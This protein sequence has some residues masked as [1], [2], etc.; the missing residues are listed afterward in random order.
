MI[1]K[2]ISA[3]ALLALLGS[4]QNAGAI[5]ILSGD[6]DGFGFTS[7]NDYENAQNGDPD[8]DG[9]GLIEAGEFLPDLDND[10][11]VQYYG[12]DQFDNREADEKS[13][14]V[15]AQWTD[16][17]LEDYYNY[18]GTGW[19]GDSPADDVVFT[20]L[21]DVPEVGDADYGVNHFINFIFG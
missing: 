16:I 18:P 8:T 6:V 15:G 7:P 11:H 21:F 3:L 17:S 4:A 20:F 2:Q 13:S 10:G 1:R 12:N 14:A 9:D 5:T 19:F